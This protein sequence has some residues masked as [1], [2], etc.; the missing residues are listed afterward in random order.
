MPQRSIQPF[1]LRWAAFCRSILFQH[2]GEH[3]FLY[4]FIAYR[5]KLQSAGGSA[6]QMIHLRTGAIS[7]SISA[8]PTYASQM[9]KQTIMYGLSASSQFNIEFFHRPIPDIYFADY[10][11]NG[12]IPKMPAVK[13]VQTVIAHHKQLSIRDPVHSC[14]LG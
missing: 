4:Y 7:V 6:P 13:A 14:V 10:I 2:S 5:V 1:C 3:K 12:H 8:R 11:F 9:K